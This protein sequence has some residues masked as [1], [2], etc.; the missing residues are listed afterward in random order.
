MN[1]QNKVVAVISAKN[2]GRTIK[3]IIRGVKK[4]SDEL[5]VVL[6]KKSTDNTKEIVTSLGVKILVDNGKGKGEGMR[7][8]IKHIKEGIILFIDADGSHI[9]KDIPKIVKPI[10]EGKADMVIG[11]R[12]LG[13]S[14]ELH[15][16]FSKLMRLF[17]S[18]CI[19]QIINWRFNKNIADTQNGFRAIRVDVAKKLKLK[20]N[21]FDI[22]TEMCMKCYKKKYKI[23][24]VPSMELERKYGISG[25]SLFKEGWIYVWRVIINL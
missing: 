23:L 14:M 19:A 6:S 16:T 10:K 15:G 5:I 13:G 7:L 11:S 20:S 9:I 21:K 12:M 18:M 17:L 4:Y 2:E 22:E 3:E 24:E 25:I 1:K 8:A